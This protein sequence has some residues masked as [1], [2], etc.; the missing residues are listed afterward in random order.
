VAVWGVLGETGRVGVNCEATVKAS[1]KEREFIG[2]GVR[3]YECGETGP[4]DRNYDCRHAIGR[5][6]APKRFNHTGGRTTEGLGKGR[7]KKMAVSAIDAHI[8]P[9]HSLFPGSK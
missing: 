7:K 3:N 9:Q 8:K 2:N 5:K 4:R 6:P 1:V